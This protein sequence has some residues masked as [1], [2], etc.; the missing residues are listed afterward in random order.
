MDNLRAPRKT[1]PRRAGAPRQPRRDTL[2]AL[3]GIE[4]ARLVIVRDGWWGEGTPNMTA[5][6]LRREAAGPLAGTCRQ[7]RRGKPERAAEVALSAANTTRFLR[8]LADAAAQPGGPYEPLVMHTDDFPSIE[9]AIHVGPEA[10]NGGLM[11]LFSSSQG[12]LHTPWCASV[13]G[14]SYAVPGTEVGRALRFIRRL[15]PPRDHRVE[16]GDMINLAPPYE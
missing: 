15:A 16:V 12:E 3:V 9:I 1:A 4:Q 10:A 5:Y 11:L 2:G 6:E 13:R 7:F 14:V 8:L